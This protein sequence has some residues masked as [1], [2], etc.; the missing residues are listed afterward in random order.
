MSRIHLTAWLALSILAVLTSNVSAQLIFNNSMSRGDNGPMPGS[1]N[2]G[3]IDGTKVC[4]GA[5]GGSRVRGACE[6]MVPTRD[7]TV[8]AEFKLPP[9]PPRSSAPLCEASTL[10]EYSQ[11]GSLAH[12]AGT[13]SIANCPAGTTGAFDLVARVKD[14]SG[15]IKPLQFSEAWELDDARDV[16]FKGEYP[17]GDDVELVSVRVRNLLCTCAQPAEADVAAADFAPA[18]LAP[19]EAASAQAPPGN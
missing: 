10:T 4:Q 3:G 8:R 9:L 1:A 14:E 15:E 5:P 7:E 13:V 2:Q 12:I 17:I 18:T 6:D 11:Q 19:A 16:T